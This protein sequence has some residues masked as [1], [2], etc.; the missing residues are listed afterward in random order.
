ME[1]L[2]IIIYILFFVC[3]FADLFFIIRL[4]CYYRCGKTDTT[5]AYLKKTHHQRNVYKGRKSGRWYKH[6]TDYVYSY[7]V[8]GKEY[9]ISCDGPWLPSALPRVISVT[10]QTKHP[11]RAYIKRLRHPDALIG[12][13][14]MSVFSVMF[15]IISILAILNI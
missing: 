13:I 3:L 9:E 5:G 15:F 14:V 8:D 7:R 11:N 4:S 2:K 6:W 12:V 10:Y 1:T